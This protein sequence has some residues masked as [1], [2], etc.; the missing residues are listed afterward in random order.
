MHFPVPAQ[1][2]PPAEIFMEVCLVLTV[3][4]ASTHRA[5]ESQAAGPHHLP[6]LTH[7]L[8]RSSWL[9]KVQAEN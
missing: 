4:Q 9:P 2:I 6:F 5:S 3:E 8:V 7:I 1:G